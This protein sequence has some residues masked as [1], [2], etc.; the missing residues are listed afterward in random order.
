MS[1]GG[2]FRSPPRIVTSAVE[3]GGHGAGRGGG[4]GGGGAGPGGR[5]RVRGEAAH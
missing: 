5:G 3:L 4:A 1:F 2:E